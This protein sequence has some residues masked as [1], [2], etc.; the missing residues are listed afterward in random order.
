MQGHFAS[1]ALLAEESADKPVYRSRVR[2]ARRRRLRARRQLI[3]GFAHDVRTPL[4][5]IHEYLALLGEQEGMEQGHRPI[6][7]VLADRV[8]DLNSA[9][10]SLSDALNLDAGT[11][12]PCRRPCK[13]VDCLRPIQIGLER[14]AALRNAS[15]AFNLPADLPEVYC[16][17]DQIRRVVQNLTARATRCLGREGSIKVWAA[18]RELQNEVR[19]GLTCRDQTESFNDNAA[20]CRGKFRVARAILRQ[21]LSEL[22]WEKTGGGTSL[23]FGL[24]I[25]NA[26]E[27][28]TRYLEKIVAW[29][30]SRSIVSLA[31]VHCCEATE[32][33][34]SREIESLLGMFLRQRDLLLPFEQRSWLVARSRK[35]PAML[36]YI[37]RVEAMRDSVNQKRPR[38]P[39]PSLRVTPLGTWRPQNGISPVLSRLKTILPPRY[40]TA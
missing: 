24:P 37:R 11:F 22:E 5:V 19:V 39:L 1:A 18:V 35:D 13:V 4:T 33:E 10:S 32:G 21:N 12:R 28:V 38:R 40:A 25:V 23:S 14:K 30:D 15:V 9:F 31:T 2:Q 7:D 29:P 36:N 6:L 20:A 34:F 26:N 16:D 3:D 27:I 17:V 8:D